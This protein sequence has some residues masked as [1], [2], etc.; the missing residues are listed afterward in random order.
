MSFSLSTVRQAGT[1]LRPFDSRLVCARDKVREDIFTITYVCFCYDL[2]VTTPFI[3]SLM[4]VLS[5]ST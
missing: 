1:N 4:V 3:L 5:P 2:P